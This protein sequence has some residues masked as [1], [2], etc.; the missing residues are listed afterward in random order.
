MPK[1]PKPFM[2]FTE[3][4][5]AVAAAYEKLGEAVH[6]AGPLDAKTRAL[7][8]LAISTGARLEGAVHSHTRKA[9]AIG[10]TPE[11]LAHVALLALPTLGLPSMMA[12]RT[13]IEDVT[14]GA[15]DKK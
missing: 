9:L 12:A 15:K 4:F 6:H 1:L 10:C 13:W 11:E 8:K 5:P 2:E 7:V 3:K 14:T